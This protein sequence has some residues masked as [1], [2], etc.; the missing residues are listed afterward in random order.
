MEALQ[1]LPDD[2]MNPDVTKH[3]PDS[4]Y[5]HSL[6]EQTGLS[7]NQAAMRFGVPVRQM[8]YYMSGE[9]PCPYPVQFCLE[10]LAQESATSET[11]P[12]RTLNGQ[13]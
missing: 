2:T 7:Q 12:R 11:S 5:L 4:K 10:C 1:R 13:R 8:R 3:N 6:L 9:K